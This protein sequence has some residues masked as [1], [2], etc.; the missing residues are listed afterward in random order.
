MQESL[1]QTLKSLESCRDS[2]ALK[3][4]Q[5]G[6][7]RECLR[8]TPAGK[9]ALTSHPEGLG[10]TLTHPHITTDYAEML[11]EFITPVA[12]DIQVTLD[13][14]TDIH[15]YTY[16]YLG[17]ELMWPL[18]MPCFVEKD[19][20]IP[21]ARYGSSHSGRMKNLYRE[22]LTHRY[23]GGMQVIAG[24]HYNF[25]IPAAMW[26]VLASADQQ[27]PDA[28][29]IS[30]RYFGLI[31]NYKRI[32]WVIPYLFGASPAIC[33]SFLEHADSQ[34]EFKSMGKGTVY[35]E[36]A[37]SLRMS[38]LGYTNKEQADLRI[39]YNSLTDYIARLRRA[40]STP[41]Q[42]FTKIGVKQTNAA[43]EIT[44]RQLNDNIL[45]IENEFYSPIRPKRVA[46]GSETPT[47]ALERG[48]V[49]YIE[50]RALDV[51]PFSPVGISAAQ[52]RMLDLL[53][54]WCLFND[55][56]ELDWDA[57]L[58]TEQNFNRVVLDGRNPR[59]TLQDNGYER[60]ISD[61][62]EELFADLQGIAAY[63]DG[64]HDD[65]YQQTVR[66]HYPMVLNPELTFSGQMM[67][68]MRDQ[69]MD[70][71]CLGMELARQYRA[72]LQQP[73]RYFT[74]AQFEQWT[75]TSI[76]KQAEREADDAGS[77][78]DAFLDDYFAKAHLPVAKG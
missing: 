44:Y 67:K 33:K 59:L 4:I 70:N 54:L 56:P 1:S 66:E 53:L 42:Q 39:T 24:V 46:Q 21:I 68:L 48:G 52:I 65:A 38:D 22:G 41:S 17:D 40:I 69:D 57:Q 14:L 72:Q 34:I 25:S 55:S 7:E 78:F 73:L 28:A 26:E 3:Q 5:R 13:Q 50:V 10:R 15:S 61:W 27:Q 16:R 36:Y 63:L 23:G 11:L 51:N 32:A 9:L 76:A 2:Q 35:R 62:L 20:E 47:Q 37:T 12:S 43:G 75:A 49:E 29:Y 71:S 60:P 77:S 19:S 18:S 45:Q 6:I 8:I 64:A 74:E 31:R 30:Q 58:I